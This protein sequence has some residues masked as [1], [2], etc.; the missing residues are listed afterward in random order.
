MKLEGGF[1]EYA[2]GGANN[3]VL[4]DPTHATSRYALKL[5]CFTTISSEGLT[6]ILAVAL[7][8]AESF[9]FFTWAFRCFMAV[10][11]VAPLAFFTDGDSA[12]DLATTTLNTQGIWT[13]V[14]LNC[15]Y[16]VSLNTYQHLGPIV[17]DV[18]N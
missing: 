13:V 2:L 17:N 14:Y 18:G 9:N 16:H 12:I 3:V 11:K 5:C 4:F 10:F 15:I 6:A 7:L 1:D 8:D